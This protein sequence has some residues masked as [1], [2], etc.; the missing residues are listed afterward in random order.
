[1]QRYKH[2]RPTVGVLPG[3]EV[4]ENAN[5]VNFLG[6]LLHGIRAA[7]HDRGCNLLLACGVGFPGGQ[8]GGIHPA[9]PVPSAEVD[10]VPVSPWNTDGLIVV[11]PLVSETRIR[12]IHDLIATGHQVVFVGTALGGPAVAMDNEGGIRQAMAHLVEHGHRRIAFIAGNPEDTHG[13]TEERLQVYR[14]ALQEY[15]LEAAP[16]LVAYGFHIVEGGR[17]AMRQLLDSG[18]PFTAVL[19]SSDECAIGAMLEL[20]EAGLRVPQDVA[21]VGFDDQPEAMLQTPPLTSVHSLTFERG[22]RA[23]ELLLEYVTGQK[24]DIE[25]VKVPTRLTV[26]QSCGCSPDDVIPTSLGP[27]W[28]PVSRASVDTTTSRLAR[29]MAETVLTEVRC[30]SS[31]EVHTLCWRLA[32]A[33]VLGL[34][35]MDSKDFR[36]TLERTL[37]RVEEV[38]DDA[39]AWQTAVSALRGELPA[40]LETWRQP[41]AHQQARNTLHQ[42]RIA[43]GEDILHRA[44]IAISEVMQHQYKQYVFDQRQTTDRVALLTA[45]LLAAL[46]ETQIFKTLAEHLPEMGIGHVGVAFFE[47]EG[48]APAAWSVLYAV[49]DLE[50]GTIRFPSRQFPPP[51]LYPEDEPFSLALLPLVIQGELTG[52]VA[53]DAANLELCG[54]IVQQ[55][56]A[57]LRNARLYREATEGR[58]L[59]E[60]GRRLAEEANR[61][62]SRFLSVVS[63]ELRTPLN[64]IVGL[65]KMILREETR[66]GPSLAEPL[67][68]DLERIHA[69]AQHLDSL[70][71]DVLDLSQCEMGQLKLVCEPLNLAEVLEVVVA[72]GEQM[73]RDKGL[74]WQVKIPEGLPQVWGDP[75]R[76]RQVALNLVG[77]AVKFTARGEVA[78]DVEVGEGKITVTV[79]DTGLGIPLKEQTLIFDEFRQSERT[80]ARGYGGLGLG[81]AICKRLVE[82]HGGEIGVR[83]S[84]QEGT[85]STFYFT[86]PVM[87]RPASRV[88]T[89]ATVLAPGQTVLLLAKQPGDGERLHKYMTRQ[90]FEMQVLQVD[91]IANWLSQG[92]MSPPGALVLDVG[93][94]SEQGWEIMKALK[95][96]PATQD[97][98]VVF[99]SLAQEGNSGSML[100]LDYLT[101]PIGM[102]ELTRALERW[103][104]PTGAGNRE[105]KTILIVDD[106]PGI[107][108]MHARIAQAQS[109][110]YRVLRA[111]DGREALELIWRERPDLVLLDLMMPELDGFGV[112]EA[113]RKG[114]TTRDI[115]VIV[116]TG[117]VLTER[118]MARLN[119]GVATVLSKGVFSAEEMLAHM[120]EAL[121]RNR[122]L[123]NETQRLVRKAMAYIHEHYTEPITREDVARCVSASKDYL[124]R[125]FRQEMRVTPM[126]YLNRYRVKQAKALLE[127]GEKNVTEVARAVGFSDSNYFSRVFRQEVGMSP[128]AYRRS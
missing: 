88:G 112:L 97:V 111:R 8:I 99:Y 69:S 2:S 48:D 6:P 122:R 47:P 50:R 17:R 24:E 119:R 110:A 62:K 52:F 66:G 126:A 86:L 49:P 10:F 44:R 33:F 32:E 74:G 77:N 108:E 59:A 75:T 40:L 94:A 92:L 96:N 116:L 113:M 31:D 127:A 30:L 26:R 9:W 64:L 11:N 56:A 63:H 18:T 53:L 57:A 101:K 106:E 68:Q 27:P 76:L 28:Q 65:S 118:D 128:S 46:D 23:L 1:M 20:K 89:A 13:D 36:L 61:M 15:G 91:E 73:A 37:R 83:S 103:G 70:I 39:H 109:A 4:Y 3:W 87:E 114:D 5:L 121:A 51:G 115:P 84:G 85:G 45:C 22:Y 117:R 107:L 104:L 14:I 21:I 82:L 79:S 29:L 120:E 105:E 78:L 55:L 54:V 72:V 100:E 16:N 98:P 34:E 19:A 41:T 124:G 102:I 43:I 80:A 93:L 60:E 42:V 71:R 25:I 81:L 95:G 67:R 125:C 58:K 7:A 38:E 35:R 12:Y 123:G 90:G